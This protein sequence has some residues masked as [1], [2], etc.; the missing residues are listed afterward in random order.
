MAAAKKTLRVSQALGHAITDKRL[1]IL[2]SLST[3]GSISQAARDA[4]VSYKA[5]WQAIDTL[6]NL[7]GVALVEKAVGGAGGG[8]ARLTPAGHQL[9]DAAQR[10]GS[11]RKQLMADIQQPTSQHAAM[12]KATL[13]LSFRT[14]MRNQFLAQVTQ[15]RV[16]GGL[17]W[18]TV[19]LPDGTPMIAKITR[20][21]AQ[22]LDLQ[23][24]VEVMVW[25]KA[26][27]VSVTNQAP[28]TPSANVLCGKVKRKSRSEPAEISVQIGAHLN[29]IGFA[30][31][32]G[33]KTGDTAYA[34][35]EDSSVVL[36]LV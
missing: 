18:V 13:A 3:A 29:L 17:A 11:V 5:A 7:S 33:I 31:H 32:A 27:A 16:S 26:T 28:I 35:F 15:L 10:L 14:S 8:G 25:C 1:Q 36:A 9:L 21:S 19:H 22:L 23:A 24:G 4:G 2:R 6:S 12:P 20:E 30:A 34:L